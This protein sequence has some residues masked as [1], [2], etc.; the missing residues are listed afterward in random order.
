M[1][2]HVMQGY[3]DTPYIHLRA[4]GLHAGSSVSP[5]AARS[6]CGLATAVE[7]LA[8]DITDDAESYQAALP[9]AC[10]LSLAAIAA[11]RARGTQ[12][13]ERCTSALASQA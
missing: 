9:A 7:Q 13:R 6:L 12:Y 5:T 4:H 11:R 10:G 2:F 3:R 8:Q 1:P